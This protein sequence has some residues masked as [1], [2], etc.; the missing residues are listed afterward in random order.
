MDSFY[1]WNKIVIA[2]DLENNKRTR[3][4]SAEIRKETNRDVYKRMTTGLWEKNMVFPIL[5]EEG[6]SSLLNNEY[7]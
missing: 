7:N 5:L 1:S 2:L 3:M 6:L 4:S